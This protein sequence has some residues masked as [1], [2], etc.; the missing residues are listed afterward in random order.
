M[1]LMF[2]LNSNIP[3]HMG[4]LSIISVQNVDLNLTWK[5]TIAGILT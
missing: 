4:Y 5:V 2:I 3:S 1:Q